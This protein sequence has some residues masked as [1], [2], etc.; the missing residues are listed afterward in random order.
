MRLRKQKKKKHKKFPVL[1]S[2][3]ANIKKESDLARYYAKTPIYKERMGSDFYRTA[4]WLRIR[5]IVLNKSDKCCSHCQ[6]RYFTLQVDHILPRSRFPELELKLS[7][8]QVLCVECNMKKGSMTY[9]EFLKVCPKFLRPL[10]VEPKVTLKLK[11]S[12]D[13]LAL[14]ISDPQPEHT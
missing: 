9:E 4:E 12:R 7:N 1:S 6:Y 5:K 3:R 8:L 13:K 14:R 11:R 2:V 10:P